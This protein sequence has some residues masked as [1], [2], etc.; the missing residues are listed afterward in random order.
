M[1]LFSL[2]LADAD[3][4]R[5]QMIWNIYYHFY[6]DE[7]SLKFLNNQAA[8]LVFLSSSMSKWNDSTY[9]RK[10]TFCDL[11]TFTQV[12]ALWIAY[13]MQHRD[14]EEKAAFSALLEAN[15]QRARDVKEHYVGTGFV[16][17]GTR[18]AAPLGVAY[19]QITHEMYHHYWSH[20]ST[21]REPDTLERTT[22][23][24]PSFAHHTTAPSTLHYG[25]DPLLGFHLAKAFVPLQQD[26]AS[27][28]EIPKSKIPVRVVEEAR[29]QFR[30]WCDVLRWSPQKLPTI[31]FFAGDAIAF[32]H[33]LHQL[34]ASENSYQGI[35]YQDAY[36]LTP[37]ELTSKECSERGSPPLKFSVIDTS[38]LIDHLGA[39]NLL[40]ATSSLL[41]DSP[42]STLYAESLVKRK[43]EHKAYIDSLLCGNFATVSLLLG[44]SPVEYWTNASSSATADDIAFDTALR[45]M[46]ADDRGQMRIKSSWKR[47]NP[48]QQSTAG[49]ADQRLRMDEVDLACIIHDIYRNMFRHEDMT[50]LFR[51]TDRLKLQESSILY[52]HRGSFAAFLRLVQSRVVVDWQILMN[53]V[54]RMI[55]IDTTVVMGHT[56]AQELCLW[57]HMLDIYSVEL[58]KRTSPV[59]GTNTRGL[60]AWKNLPNAV[61]ITLKVP[62][63]R[64]TA[65]TGP[66]P[67]DVGTPIAHCVLQSSSRSSVGQWQNIFSE[68]RIVFGEILTAGPVNS[69][70]FTV[71]VI[72]DESKWQGNAPLVVSFVTPSW[73][74]L[75]EP[76]T[77]VIAFGLQSTPHASAKFIESLGIE[78]SI[79]ETTLGDSEH[80]YISRIPPNLTETALAHASNGATQRTT[81]MTHHQHSTTITANVTQSDKSISSL[82]VRTDLRSSALR[83]ALQS[84]CVVK[85]TQ[86]APSVITITIVLTGDNCQLLLQFPAPIYGTR[87][88]TR[89]ARK[90]SY[91][92]VEAPIYT[93]AWQL[94]PS[95]MSLC[96]PNEAVTQHGGFHHLDMEILPALDVACHDRLKWL[97]AH[98]AGMFSREERR[99]REESQS[100]AS[101]TN[102]GARVSFKDSL[103]S[104][105]MHFTGLQG[106]KSRIFGLDYPTGGGVHVLIFVSC[107][108]LDVG[109]QT[110]VLDAAVLPLT[111]SLVSRIGRFLSFIATRGICSIKVDADEL[112][113]WRQILPSFAERCR[114]W[115]HKPSCELVHGVVCTTKDA[116]DV[117]CSCGKGKLPVGFI[118]DIPNWRDVVE[119]TTRTAISPIFSVPVV[120]PPFD[121]GVEH[122]LAHPP[123]C[124]TCGEVEAS[125]GGKLFKCSG[126]HIAK[127]CSRDCQTRNWRSHKEQCIKQRRRDRD[128]FHEEQ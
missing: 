20:G 79:F 11:S 75:L 39:L 10:M 43:K 30:A 7:T 92:E 108:R 68:I 16:T 2:I 53:H 55:E 31:R 54:F 113:L 3:G 114:T 96:P 121:G 84:G 115:Q 35:I 119:F 104:L 86:T 63:Q 103:F 45:L 90:S 12:R 38:N 106:G 21:D 4:T 37:I 9:G 66:K 74:L 65:L 59:K 23:P 5:Q 27:K 87:S 15:I 44:L 50:W 107:V 124:A 41:K 32:T 17:T 76:Q 51:G 99:L 58:F 34:D 116:N 122:K 56:Y 88:K 118:K 120:D 128:D 22:F 64:L 61:C 46:G 13:S 101:N 1:L 67:T 98:V 73:F 71:R 83:H 24:N 72:E 47:F 28:C 97:V 127:Y 80:V 126:C 77:T 94:F 93:T 111:K 33:A 112:S 25:T 102:P 14:G 40:S 82:C 105:F 123:G 60:G 91:I 19:A 125:V 36:H 8:E 95:F 81:Q 69:N 57:L 29:A 18:S 110:V 6:L 89:I 70:D 109:S 42:S 85:I 49:N 52:Y 48:L 100:D 26:P 62:R 117:F 78:L